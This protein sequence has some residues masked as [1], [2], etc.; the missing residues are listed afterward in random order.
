MGTRPPL[1]SARATQRTSGQDPLEKT[2]SS[3]SSSLSWSQRVGEE[4]HCLI[5]SNLAFSPPSRNQRSAALCSIFGSLPYS[6]TPSPHQP[7]TYV[8]DITKERERFRKFSA[9]PNPFPP[10]CVC[11]CTRTQRFLS[12]KGGGRCRAKLRP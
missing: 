4:G 1:P 12:K 5:K 10:T 8:Q 3:S 9:L 7:R 6:R 11:V 2:P